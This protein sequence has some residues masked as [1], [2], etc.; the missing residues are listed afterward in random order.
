MKTIP[1]NE[2]RRAERAARLEQLPSTG[3]SREIR[4]RLRAQRERLK[5]SLQQV[6]DRI[7]EYIG[8][9]S[10]SASSVSHY[11]H[12]RRHP[13]V[14]VFAA[15]AR[16]VEMKLL[17]DVALLSEAE[18]SVVVSLTPRVAWIARALAGASPPALDAIEAVIRQIVPI[19]PD[20]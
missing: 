2:Q 5:L 6:A 14:D 1:E 15:W 20:E 8:E 18:Q 16:A 3:H 9:E 12:F 13:P 11:E 19:H 17:V 4:N 7:A 10:F